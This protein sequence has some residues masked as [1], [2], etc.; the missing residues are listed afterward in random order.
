M[1]TMREDAVLTPEEAPP[2]WAE[3]L[4]AVRKASGALLA[5]R[6]AIFREEL[7]QKTGHFARAAAGLAVAAA[8]GVASLFVFTALLAA[9]FARWFGSTALGLLGVLVLYAAIAGAGVAVGLAA[10]RRAREGGFPVTRGELRKDWEA[11]NLARKSPDDEPPPEED[12]ARDERFSEETA[13]L[14]DPEPEEEQADLEAR[15]RERSE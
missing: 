10:L 9:L 5:T 15:F 14:R 8:F 12:L 13:R 4:E 7:S 1:S 6:V 11:L 2:G 3:R